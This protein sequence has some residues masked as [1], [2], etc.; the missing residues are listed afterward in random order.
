MEPCPTPP[1]QHAG[2]ALRREGGGSRVRASCPPE[3]RTV[4][5][6]EEGETMRRRGWGGLRVRAPP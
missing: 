6:A 5:I 4:G 1:A 2:A 3:A